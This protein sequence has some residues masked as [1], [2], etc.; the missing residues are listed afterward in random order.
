MA[1]TDSVP[2]SRPGQTGGTSAPSAGAEVRDC[3]NINKRE[4]FLSCECERGSEG[5]GNQ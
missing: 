3:P 5:A 1:A 2:W 4:V